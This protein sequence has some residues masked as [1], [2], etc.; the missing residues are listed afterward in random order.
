MS[1]STA[2]RTAKFSRRSG[3]FGA[4]QVFLP[5]LGGDVGNSTMRYASYLA[6]AF[7][8]APEIY[9]RPE[10]AQNNNESKDNCGFH[11]AIIAVRRGEF[12]AKSGVFA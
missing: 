11:D 2:A 12:E 6:S 4:V 7:Y 10:Q 8:L 5:S 9:T 1:V 3:D